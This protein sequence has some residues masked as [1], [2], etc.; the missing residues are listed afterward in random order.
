MAERK[1]VSEEELRRQIAVGVRYQ[2]AP[3]VQVINASPLSDNPFDMIRA[4][5]DD[6]EDL[7]NKENPDGAR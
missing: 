2:L 1:E 5:L 6:M 4:A 3:L 7:Y